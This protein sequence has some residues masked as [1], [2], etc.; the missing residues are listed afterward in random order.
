M[1]ERILEALRDFFHEEMAPEVR[2]DWA[3]SEEIDLQDLAEFLEHR[4]STALLAAVEAPVPPAPPRN[5]AA[6]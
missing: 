4:L 2:L 3:Y 1:K 6:G 5:P